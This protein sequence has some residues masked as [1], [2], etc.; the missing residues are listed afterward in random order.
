MAKLI[1][2]KI[3]VDDFLLLHPEYYGFNP[4]LGKDLIPRMNMLLNITEVTN[5]NEFAELMMKVISVTNNSYILLDKFMGQSLEAIRSLNEY[6]IE[7]N[8][9]K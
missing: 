9:K 1:S 3:T 5:A 6:L 8:F 7:D 4:E 2:K